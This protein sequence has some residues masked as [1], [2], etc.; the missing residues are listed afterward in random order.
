LRNIGGTLYFFTYSFPNSKLW[1]SDGS[2]AGTVEVKSFNSC[3]ITARGSLDFNGI[4]LSIMPNPTNNPNHDLW[5]SDGTEAGTYIIKE[6]GSTILGDA[7]CA[8]VGNTFY[9]V[10]STPTTGGSYSK[11]T[12]N[13]GFKLII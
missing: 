2:A 9:F 4:Y 13:Y 10:A 5:R 6:M 1:K 7:G 3:C 12:K 8:V 11:W